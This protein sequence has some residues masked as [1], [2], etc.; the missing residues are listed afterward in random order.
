MKSCV[1][2]MGI[3]KALYIQFVWSNEDALELYWTK[4]VQT[5]IPL[6]N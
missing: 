3:L 6:K 4:Q 2:S 5:Q 1:K